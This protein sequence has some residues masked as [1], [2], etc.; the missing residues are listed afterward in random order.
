MRPHSPHLNLLRH[1]PAVRA[2][3]DQLA[4]GRHASALG[5]AGSSTSLVASAIA[6]LTDRPVLLLV[7][8]LDDADEAVDELTA[9]GVD[10]ARFPALEFLPGETSV[11]L[12]LFAERLSIVRRLASA[13]LPSVLLCPV[14]ALMQ[15]VPDPARLDSLIITLRPG[16]RRPLASLTRWLDNA[17]YKRIESIEEPG[18][19]ALRGGILDI[20]P[21]SGP[22]VRLD[23]FG[24]DLESITEIDLDTMASASQLAEL[25]LVGARLADADQRDAESAVSLLDLLPPRALAILSETIEITE[26]ARGYFERVHDA[27][28]IFGPPHVL[29]ALRDRAHATA[30]INHFSGG[31]GFQPSHSQ[32]ITL[33]AR[34]IPELARDA[35]EAVADLGRL[36][37]DHAVTVF[38]QNDGELARFKELI[39]EFA[40]GAPI[41]ALTCYLHRGFIWDCLPQ[42]SRLKPQVFLPYHELLHRYN[43]RRRIRRLKAGRATDAFLEINIGDYVVHAD[44]GI[45][46]FVGLKTLT[47]RAPKP[48]ADQRADELLTTRP[49]TQDRGPSPLPP[50]STSTSLSDEYLVLEFAGRSRLNVPV[51]HIDKVQRYIGG[52]AGKPPLST[53]GGKRWESQKERVRE[54][55]KDLA[56]ELLRVQAARESM[57]GVRYPDDTAWQKE[58]EAEFPYEETDDQLASLVEIK[59]DM[60]RERPMDRLLCG[61]VGYGKTE[62]AIRAAFKAV[63][64][65]KQVAVLVPT[66]LLAEQH[67]RTFRQRFADYPFRIESLSRFK[68]G[69]EQNDILA[70]ARKGQVDVLIGTHRL[71]S[72]DV[73]FGDLGLVVVDE[74]QRFGVEHKNALLALRLTVD[75]LTLSA[76][77]IPRTLHMAMLGLR[78]ISSLSTP[79]LDRRAVVTEVIPYNETRVQ[80][81]IHREL[82]R[83]GQVYFVHNRVHNIQTV[84]DD[85]QKLA[86]DARIVIGHGQ[87]PDDELERVMRTFVTRQADIL[88]ST[89]IIESGIDIPTANTMFI[90]HADRFGLADLHQLRGRVGRYKHRAYCYMLL[91]HDRPVTDVA[92]RRLRAIE[93]F[94]MLGAGFKIAMRDLEIRG[95]GNLLG[96]EQSGH[97]AAVG[98]DMYCRLLEH[99]ARELKH[100]AAA[101]PAD[102]AVEIGLSGAFPKT[103][104]PSESRRIEAYR[105]LGAARSL[106]EINRIEEDLKTA[107]GEPPAAVATALDLARLRIGAMA[108]GVR[109]IALHEQDIIIRCRAPDPVLAALDGVKGSLRPLTQKPGDTLHEIYFRPPPNYLEP[110]SLL[111]ILRRRFTS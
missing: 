49:K 55:V 52:F 16:E 31:A 59:K 23:F 99:A 67:E 54:S 107:Y 93:E 82:A 108:L 75:V 53:L 85:L 101:E 39:A 76:T 38:C 43:T 51:A 35:A 27:R 22:P 89:T 100:E 20:F 88:V 69:K 95:A 34:P 45:A 40:Q 25:E 41:H 57:P 86:P 19:F 79:P 68:T 37:A 92:V 5:S 15:A 18:D 29:K 111:T 1:D 104:I 103:Y 48:A 13:N 77:P 80:Q 58:F 9:A 84:A 33:P 50:S 83:E 65:G 7:A 66:T 2:L 28:G 42:A 21:A 56:A 12:E 4:S 24:D 90:N 110:H 14:Q 8:H 71:L 3:A 78:D 61:D 96:A 94:S 46:R 36:T 11:S 102:T 17:G 81:A 30:E 62:L 47:P 72:K 6:S 74:E 26:Q 98:Y 73:K 91:P 105:R 97:I 60:T 64:F 10:A 70:A 87:M 32:T 106:D 63:E 109:S 44:H